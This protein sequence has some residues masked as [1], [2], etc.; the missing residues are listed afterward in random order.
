MSPELLQ[1]FNEMEQRLTRLERVENVSFIENMARRLQ[2]TFNIPRRLSDL[3]DVSNTDDAS[4]GQ[5]LKKTGTT[6]QPGTDN[7]A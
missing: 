4:P 5:V 1:K 3:D 2:E 7:T 6:W